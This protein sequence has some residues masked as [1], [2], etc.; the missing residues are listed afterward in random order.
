M[1][2]PLLT[3]D[4]KVSERYVI[5]SHTMYSTLRCAAFIV[6][7]FYRIGPLMQAGNFNWAEHWAYLTSDYERRYNPNH[8]GVVYTHGKPVFKV[9]EHHPFLDVIEQC[10]V[11]NP[12]DYDAAIPMTEDFF[13]KAGKPVRIDHAGTIGLVAGVMADRQ[14]FGLIFRNPKHSGTFNFTITIPPTSQTPHGAEAHIGLLH[15]A[16]L[17]ES[18]QLAVN[19]GFKEAQVKEG[20]AFESEATAVTIDQMKRQMGRV[21]AELRQLETRLPIA[22]RPD[23]PDMF[24]LMDE[25]EE[26]ARLEPLREDRPN[27]PLA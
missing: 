8:W 2:L 14:R 18:I 20:V 17:F 15:A 24:V 12:S 16:A 27:V 10:D 21:Q 9:G 25:A 26:Y 5:R 22:Y 13:A 4:G 19:I 11:R 23:R 6:R 1:V 3:P 7:S